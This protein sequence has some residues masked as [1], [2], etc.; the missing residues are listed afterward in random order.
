MTQMEPT[1]TMHCPSCKATYTNRTSRNYSVCTECG[2]SLVDDVRI[3]EIEGEEVGEDEDEPMTE[4]E[5]C[6]KLHSIWCSTEHHDEDY[7]YVLQFI[8]SQQQR[9][10][11]LLQKVQRLESTHPMSEY[12][13]EC[14]EK[15]KEVQE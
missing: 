7:N 9:I 8:Y 15:L 1:Q 4:I 2:E 14:I 11:E 13:R 12:K 5:A 3:E 10:T 6:S